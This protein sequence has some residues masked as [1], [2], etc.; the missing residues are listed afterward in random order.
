MPSGF[1]P[2]THSTRSSAPL[3]SPLSAPLSAGSASL[4]LPQTCD[5]GQ[6]FFAVEDVNHLKVAFEYFWNLFRA[7]RGQAAQAG[8][9]HGRRVVSLHTLMG[10][11]EA[12]ASPDG[13]P[14][15]VDDQGSVVKG[16]LYAGSWLSFPSVLPPGRTVSSCCSYTY[17]HQCE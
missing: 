9:T 6:Y 1:I 5:D 3:S 2:F 7:K 12:G 8:T 10:E 14:E 15:V 4:F 17:E 13:R 16:A 11:V